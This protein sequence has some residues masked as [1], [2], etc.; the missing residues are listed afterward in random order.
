MDIGLRPITEHYNRTSHG[1]HPLYC[2]HK[3][4]ESEKESEEI[5]ESQEKQ[6]I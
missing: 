5:P 1:S 6:Q 2:S 3:G 4:L